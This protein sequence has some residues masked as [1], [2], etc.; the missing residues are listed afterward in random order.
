MAFYIR[1]NEP[2]SL[3]GLGPKV[4]M[5][6]ERPFGPGISRVPDRLALAPLNEPKSLQDASFGSVL[7]AERARSASSR[8][9]ER[10]VEYTIKENDTLWGLAVKR[11]HVNV[12]DIIKD[13][14][15]E[16]PRKIQPGQKIRVRIPSYPGPMNV[17]ASWYGKEHHG[18]AMANGEIF[19]MNAATIAHKEIPLGTR[20]ELEN[21]TTGQRARAVVA[22][23]GPYVAGR[24]VDLSYA[25]AKK[26]SLLEK[27]VA[28]LVMRVQG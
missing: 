12:D 21:P 28:P 2:A 26:L 24:D 5:R 16:D 23:R 6:I 15:I 22:D 19:D 18:R 10:W 9:A 13:N 3:P 25:L 17:V 20:V 4:R 1:R 7:S 27:G 14:G 11:F 8:T